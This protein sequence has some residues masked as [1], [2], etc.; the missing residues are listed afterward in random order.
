MFYLKNGNKKLYICD[1]VFTQ[2]PQCGKEFQIDLEAAVIDGELDLYGLSF[3]CQKCRENMR[4]ES[5]RLN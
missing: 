2:C 1:N 5:R 3:F 4:N